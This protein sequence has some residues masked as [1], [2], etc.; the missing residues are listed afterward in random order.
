MAKKIRYRIDE[1]GWFNFEKLI[2]SLLKAELGMGIESWGGHSDLGRDSYYEGKLNFPAK[3]IITAGPFLFQVKFIQGANAAGAKPD[4]GIK[5]AIKEEIKKIELLSKT[6]WK[7]T[8]NHYSLLTNVNL[9]TKL[10]KTLRDEFKNLFNSKQIHL[11]G[12][13]DI[14]D[15]LDL[16]PNL[17]KTFPELMGIRDIEGLLASTVNSAIVQRSRATINRAIEISKVFVFTKPYLEA[18]KT[19]GTHNFVVL[20]G[21][22]EMGKTS[23]A[24]IIGLSQVMSKWEV[25]ECLG[26]TDFFKSYKPTLNQ[27]FIFD[28]AFG[29]T[30][31][32]PSLGRKW[33][34]E[35]PAILNNLDKHHWLI[36][37]SRT[38]ILIRALKN[39][40][41][42][43][44]AEK[45]PK[46][47]EI[48]VL[49][50]TL[51]VEEKARILYRH[52]KGGNLNNQH[53][54]LIK[55]N[56][57]EIVKAKHFTPER[58]RR[59][60][61]ESLPEIEK[62]ISES[63]NKLELIKKEVL[64]AI[65][66]PTER[67]KKAFDNLSSI[68]QWIL[69][70]YLETQNYCTEREI[71]KIVSNYLDKLSEKDFT[72]HL[73]DLEGT[74]LKVIQFSTSSYYDWIHP[75][76][77][78]LV[79]D[80]LTEDKNTQTAFLKS[81]T[82][83]GVKL[84]LSYEGGSEGERSLPFMRI[85]ENWK[86]LEEGCKKICENGT[87]W[88]IGEVLISL[89]ESISIEK[90]AKTVEFLKNII[91]AVCYSSRIRWNKEKEILTPEVL[92]S[93][94]KASLWVSPL[95]ALPD[96]EYSFEI[97]ESNFKET[98]DNFYS[99]DSQTPEFVLLI[100]FIKENEPRLL[101]KLNFSENIIPKLNE[102]M[103][104]SEEC[105][106]SFASLD[107]QDEYNGEC[108]YLGGVETG[109]REVGK[110]LADDGKPFSEL[111]DRIQSK[112]EDLQ[113]EAYEKFGSGG[114]ENPVAAASNEGERFDVDLFFTDF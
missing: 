26:P 45:F 55:T 74:F 32:D 41:L 65:E 47:S 87:V 84:A 43:G 64:K 111:A 62:D 105:V 57:K 33:E 106:S 13:D 101:K 17:R 12:L 94:A 20:D 79:I 15:F 9:T 95:P 73:E 48:T 81:I 108:E 71:F 25:F 30:E 2:Q 82:T 10:R 49:A 28:D 60:M 38:H 46:P 59:F 63:P 24:R 52:G 67:M 97:E 4:A 42:E 54:N 3:D 5:K 37:T 85:D 39:M 23:I 98:L 34:K 50:D 83:N 75:S 88:E 69:I 19:L 110:V 107:S 27:V 114:D 100:K 92:D 40:D 6:K 18:Y 16:H 53:R 76:Y 1:L 68:H 89:D 80:K 70:A 86:L 44:K 102:F 72:A 35:L 14:C 109:L 77:R 91:E 78:D 11:L 56:A 96:I 29:R 22:P 99:L 112:I 8:P 58:I 104:L 7:T 93:Y 31:F 90:G 66:N 51:S 61:V 36:I 103:E 113:E 21:P